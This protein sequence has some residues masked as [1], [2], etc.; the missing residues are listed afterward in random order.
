MV[1]LCK[2]SDTSK[3]EEIRAFPIHPLRVSGTIWYIWLYQQESQTKLV[4]G[5]GG[6]IVK[7]N[8][9]NTD[10]ASSSA[11][12]SSKYYTGTGISCV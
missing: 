11:Y 5:S 12:N 1:V 7:T 6:R 8:G 10:K 4:S 3:G 9:V 2:G